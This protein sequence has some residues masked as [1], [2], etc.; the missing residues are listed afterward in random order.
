M[1]RGSRGDREPT[2]EMIMLAEFGIVRDAATCTRRIVFS[3]VEEKVA[4]RLSR[5]A[6]VSFRIRRRAS[7]YASDE[8]WES[9]EVALA[10][11]MKLRSNF[12]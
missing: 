1:S 3:H 6:R 12:D 2:K 7:R 9:H 5:Q 11:G 10:V 4:T 8:T